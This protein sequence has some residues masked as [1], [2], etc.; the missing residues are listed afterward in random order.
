MNDVFI[1]YAHIDDQAL[2][3]GQKGWITQFHRILEVRLGQLLGEKPTIWRDQKLQGSDVF[4]D[5]IVNAFREAKV[6]ISIM[7]PRYM[8]SEWC[9]KE[10]NEFYKAASDG[11]SIKVGEKARIFKVIKTPIDARDIPEHIPQV[12][13]SILG[14]EFFDFD[15]DTGRLVEYDEAFGE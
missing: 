2:T 1:S 15:P 9:L 4:D 6:M 3:E 14:F 11:G 12:L 8:K 13:Q 5:K 10:L 7:S